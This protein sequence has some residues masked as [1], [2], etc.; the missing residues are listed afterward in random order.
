MK[1]R[2]LVLSLVAV[3]SATCL[4][5]DWKNLDEEHHLGGRRTSAGYLRGKVVL[6]DRW[7]V[8]CPPCRALLPRVEQVWQSFKTK[9]FVVL[10]GHCKGWGDAEGV[11]ALVDQ[12]GLTYPIYED[13]GLAVGEP[14]FDAIPFIY[15][16][17]ET[18]LVV[19]R[20]HDERTATQAVVTALTDME[21]P[22]NLRQWKRFLDFEVENLP[23]RA[24]QR[25]KEFKKNFPNEAKAYA[26]KERAIQAIPDVKTL[27]ELVEFA[28]KSKDMPAF[29]DN[30]KEKRQAYEKTVRDAIANPNY[31]ALLTSKD[32][33]VVQE[34]KNSLADLKWTAASF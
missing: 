4:A 8:R 7:G 14:S 25:L 29:T 15:V 23:G 9:P 1:T 34:A 17:D 18:G 32:P 12:H 13:A 5:V 30:Q 31:Q 16:V 27:S 20:G 28:R 24:Y 22:R 19:Y 10:G 2:M 26:E 33:R 3:A 21:S 6:V 11:K